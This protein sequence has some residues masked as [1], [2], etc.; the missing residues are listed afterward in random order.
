VLDRTAAQGGRVIV[1]REIGAGE[2][3]AAPTSDATPLA[4]RVQGEGDAAAVVRR[5]V[6]DAWVVEALADVPGAF[7]GVAVTRAGRAWSARTG[8][9]RQA[10]AVGDEQ[11]LA[12]RNRREELIA[13][14]ER[15]AQE[16]LAAQRERET[17]V[18]EL[19]RVAGARDAALAA[20]RAAVRARDEAAERERELTMRMERRRSESAGGAAAARHARLNA[21]LESE[22][23][24]LERLERERARRQAGIE[25]LQA[26]TADDKRALPALREA[27]EVLVAAADAIA[28]QRARFEQE[29]ARDREAGEAIAAKLRQCAQ[30][31]AGL[32]SELHRENEALMQAEVGA[33]RAGDRE[34]EAG[35]ELAMLAARLG[36]EPEPASAPLASEEREALEQRLERLARRREQLGPVNPLAETEYEEAV[37][38]VEELE[39]QRRDL[40]TA[41]RELEAVIRDT[42]KQ[43]DECFEQTFAAAARNFEEVVGRLFPGGSGRLRLVAEPDGPARAL[44]GQ[45]IPAEDPPEASEEV[46]DEPETLG[47]E[48]ELMPAGKRMQRLTLLSGGEKSLTALAFLFA[49]FLA[50][51][52]PF[53]ILDEV[54]AALDDLNIDRFLGLLRSFADRAQFIVVTHQK[55]T[56]EAADVLYGVVMGGDGITKVISRRLET[57]QAA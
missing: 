50:R 28:T 33:Q 54:E 32:Q 51:P 25:R 20:H 46:A 38:H 7:A 3:V 11:I 6:R 2:A 57:A 34:E 23:R 18:G 31:E 19:E 52:C 43:I 22:R 16:E 45:Q 26:A 10:P 55:R 39:H 12:Q 53:Y 35:A 17:A 29:L 27:A 40:E 48:I 44:G 49:V 9:L 30:R 5:L 42:D 21:E 47:I 13:A 41:L 8:E 56:M 15:A 4:D 24:A 1:A 37:A 14:T 36:L